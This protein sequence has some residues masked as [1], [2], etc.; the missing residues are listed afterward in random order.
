MDLWFLPGDFSFSVLT[1]AMLA[2]FLI[3]HIVDSDLLIAA[4]ACF[5]AFSVGYLKFPLDFS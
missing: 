3:L 1:L 4:V 5:I 2:S